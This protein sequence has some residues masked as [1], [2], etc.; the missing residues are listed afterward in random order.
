M[1]RTPCCTALS[2]FVLAAI[3]SA[4]CSAQ[5][6]QTNLASNVSGLAA[7]TDASLQNPW[8]ISFGPTTPFWLSNQVTGNATLYDGGGAA[9]PLVV[10]IPGGNPTGQ[11][12]NST[13]DFMLSNGSKATFMFSTLNGTIVGWNGVAGTSGLIEADVP[14]DVYT[15][16][17]LGNN[18]SANFLYVA[19]EDGVDVFDSAFAAASLPGGF[20]DPNLP[21]G[22]TPYNIA[23]IGG[24]LFVT[25]ENET[26]GGGIIDRFDLNGNLLTRFTSN[27]DSG[28]LESP[29]GVVQAPAT[30][31]QFGGAILVG[32]EDDGHISAFNAATGQFLG[33][34]IQPDNTPIANTGLW[35]LAFGNG[36]ASFDPNSLYFAAGIND[37][38][39][40]L[41]GRITAVPEPG[42]AALGVWCLMAVEALTLRRRARC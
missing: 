28:P 18:G 25:Y 40:G 22:F 37:E 32:N 42:F 16:L 2:S 3:L 15:G 30:F 41:F 13:N 17:A 38:N 35:G 33:Q 7:H 36:N 12:F 29:W 20:T 10:T 6:V 31:G 34:L 1:T 5:Y 39:D 11:V 9:Q 24:T 4:A 21:A 27:D 19:G 26:S 8:G 14:G 23:N